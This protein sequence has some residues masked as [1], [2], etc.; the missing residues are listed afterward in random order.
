[1]REDLWR[2]IPGSPVDSLVRLLGQ[3]GIIYPAHRVCRATLERAQKPRD[4]CP[5][6]S[7][8][9][10][11]EVKEQKEGVSTDPKGRGFDK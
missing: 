7:S 6:S 3:M 9:G 11:W 2:G 8:A 4:R 1:M 5:N 10:V